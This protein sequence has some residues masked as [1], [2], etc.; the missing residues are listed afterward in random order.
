MNIPR[1]IPGALCLAASLCVAAATTAAPLGKDKPKGEGPK[2]A[3]PKGEGPKGAG[4]KGVHDLRKAYDDLT[5]LAETPPPGKDAGKLLDHAKGFYRAAVAAF[6][7][8]PRRARELAVA[9]KDAVRGLRHARRATAKPVPG[10]PEPPAG[11][12]PAPPRDGPKG[13][14]PPPPPDDGP[15][16]G[17]EPWAPALEALR[18][19]REWVSRGEAS[20]RGPGRD[21][22]EAARRA[23]ARGR[24]AYEEGEYRAAGEFARAAEAWA[25]VGEHLARSGD[26]PPPPPDRPAPPPGRRGPG[27]PPPPPPV[28]D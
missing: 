6:P 11:D 4:P 17:R 21:F 23:Y 20:P 22:A 8:D 3:G 1:R 7:D 16:A 10:L 26:E 24:Q 13:K 14:A 15:G 18:A 9:A 27:A 19:A 28:G 5:E 25:H 2:K 12:R